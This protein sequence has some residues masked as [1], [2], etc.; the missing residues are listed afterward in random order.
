MPQLTLFVH[1]TQELKERLDYD[2]EEDLMTHQIMTFWFKCWP[3]LIHD[4]SLVGYILSPNP[5]IMNNERE[6]MLCSP[7]Y[8]HAIKHLIGKLLVPEHLTSTER[9]ECLGEMTTKFLMSTKSLRTRQAFWTMTQSGTRHGR[10]TLLLH[11]ILYLDAI[12]NQ[13]T[14]KTGLLGFIQNFRNRNSR[15]QLE[16]GVKD[17]VW[18]PC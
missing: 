11:V 5:R 6:R 16:T 1:R 2:K 4:Y 8:S 9:K 7:I 12:E 15:T 13:G 3:K 18:R 10:V 14:W 17:Q